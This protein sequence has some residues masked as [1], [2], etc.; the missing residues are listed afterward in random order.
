MPLLYITGI[1]QLPLGAFPLLGCIHRCDP[2]AF[3]IL[4]HILRFPVTLLWIIGTCLQYNMGKGSACPGWCRHLL[5]GYAPCQCILL[6]PI[7]NQLL[8]QRQKR[9]PVLVHQLI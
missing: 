1:G 3:Q 2:Q 6:I 5:P 7:G 8:I 4:K 9:K